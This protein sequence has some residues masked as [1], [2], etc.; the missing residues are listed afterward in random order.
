MSYTL[1]PLSN[2]KPIFSV[3]EDATLFGKADFTAEEES[4]QCEAALLGVAPAIHST[5]SH[6]GR[7]VLL[8][9]RVEGMSLADFYGEEDVPSR[10]W[11]EVREILQRLWCNGI[12]FEDITPY[13]FMIEPESGKVWV[14]DFG[15]ARRVAM[16]PALKGILNGGS[17]WN[18][19]YR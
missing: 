17:V 14:V 10:V 16:C 6:N 18:A 7:S 2:T 9:K 19:E 12:E 4:L 5:I 1:V 13:N 15:H 11:V 3:L 8:M